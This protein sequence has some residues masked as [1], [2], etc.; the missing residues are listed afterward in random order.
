MWH[1]TPHQKREDTSWPSTQR[2]NL[3]NGTFS[4]LYFATVSLCIHVEFLNDKRWKE[5][6]SWCCRLNCIINPIINHFSSKF[7]FYLL[8]TNWWLSPE[9]WSPN[10]FSTHHGDQ[11]GHS[12]ERCFS[13]HGNWTF[14]GLFTKWSCNVLHTVCRKKSVLFHIN[15]HHRWLF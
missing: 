2:A 11:N 7:L 12:L 13:N 1:I 10:I 8:V 4:T 14:H 3:L 6:Y 15:I 5:K 9:F